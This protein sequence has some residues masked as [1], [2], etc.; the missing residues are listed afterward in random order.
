MD[1]FDLASALFGTRRSETGGKLANSVSTIT[2]TGAVDSTN[3]A[4]GIVFDADVTPAD[5][6]DGDDTVIDIP[7]SPDVSSGDDVLVSLSGDG[8]LKAPMVIANPGSGDRQKAQTAAAAALAAAAQAVAEATGQHFWEDSNGAHVT[9]VTQ[10]EWSDSGDPNY[11]SGPNSL[12]NALGMLFRDGLTNLLA[13]LPT[14][15]AIYDGLG[16]DATNIVANFTAS[17]IELGKNSTSSIISLCG[18]SGT[19]EYSSNDYLNILKT[20]ASGNIR[21]RSLIASHDDSHHGSSTVLVGGIRSNLTGVD[22]AV[23]LVVSSD[24]DSADPSHMVSLRVDGGTNGSGTGVDETSFVSVSA[25]RT[26]LIGENSS[27]AISIDDVITALTNAGVSD[28][29]SAVSASAWISLG[30]GWSVDSSGLVYNAYR[31][32]LVGNLVIKSTATHSSG[33]N[34]LGTVQSS[35]LPPAR[36]VIDTTSTSAYTIYVNA[37]GT[38][39]I[40]LATAAS[41]G[42]TYYFALDYQV[43]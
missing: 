22:A 32:R 31:K 20:V 36:I 33:N 16:N 8:P 12:W 19:I 21:I 37:N 41:N 24:T 9:Q 11:H 34:T 28:S 4:A 17:L 30:T 27:A 1:M 3:G 26:K 23:Q 18:G 38:T 39:T 10:D 40:A 43:A 29:W 2:G 15:I 42:S 14:G 25:Y 35:Y 13:V 5:D 6:Y 7:T